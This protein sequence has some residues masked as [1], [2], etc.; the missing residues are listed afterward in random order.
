VNR[1]I[2]RKLL[3]E[4][5][6]SD[7]KIIILGSGPS[8]GILNKK[9]KDRRLETSAIIST[10]NRN[11]LINATHFLKEQLKEYK[12]KKIT[13]VLLSHGHSDIISGLPSLPEKI[14]AYALKETFDAIHRKFKTEYVIE[15]KIE[16]YKQFNIDDIKITPVSVIHDEVNPDRFPCTCWQIKYKNKSIIFCDDFTITKLPLKSEKYFMNND[17]AFLDCAVKHPMIGHSTFQELLPKVKT[18]HN[19]K[20]YLIQ[21][22]KEWTHQELTN[23]IKKNK[24]Y[25]EISVSYDGLK[26]YL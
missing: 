26:I 22:G 19:N 10:N 20:T 11:I 24:L 9:G 3:L 4:K 5:I 12:I 25:P 14:P 1:Y 16:P 2:L 21:I 15:N 23:E 18:W 13:A 8:G 7:I 6:V 17:I